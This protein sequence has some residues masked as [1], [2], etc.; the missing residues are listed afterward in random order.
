MKRRTNIHTYLKA[1][2]VPEWRNETNCENQEYFRG[3]GGRKEP[4]QQ[5]LAGPCSRLS[6]SNKRLFFIFFCCLTANK[7]LFWITPC[8]VVGAAGLLLMLG[9][10]IS[11][12]AR[13]IWDKRISVGKI[14][15]SDWTVGNSVDHFLDWWLLRAQPTVGS[16]T[17]GQGVLGSRIKV[18]EW[19]MRRKPVSKAP[20]GP[21]HQFLSPGSS[22]ELLPTSLHGELTVRRKLK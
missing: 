15:P 14:L 6:S 11:T 20:Q 9:S 4:Q 22:L 13:V 18:D 2:S 3:L 10:V 17:P 16:I 12:Q 7:I 5:Q 21:L 19:A 1:P 8:A